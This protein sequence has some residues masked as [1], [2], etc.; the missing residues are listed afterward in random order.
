MKPNSEQQAAIDCREGYWLWLA[1]AGSGKTMVLTK[2]VMALLTENQPLNEILALT[3]TS[4]AA[5]DML[6]RLGIKM[7][8]S[9]IILY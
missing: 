8:K 1:T 4:E 9:Y 7:S 2:R 5:D 3:F 6:G